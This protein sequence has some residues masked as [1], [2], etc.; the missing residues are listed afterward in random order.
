MKVLKYDD[1]IYFNISKEDKEKLKILATNN[2]TSM[3]GIVRKLINNQ[4]ELMENQL[5][6]Y[7]EMSKQEK[8]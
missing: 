5:M 6:I 4:L 7:K 8:E 3:N 1:R 2:H